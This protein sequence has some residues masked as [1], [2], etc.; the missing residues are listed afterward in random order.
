M[1]GDAGGVD[2]IGAIVGNG[3]ATGG[4]GVGA[5]GMIFDGWKIVPEGGGGPHYYLLLFLYFKRG[6]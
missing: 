6:V 3:S 5:E 4:A 1:V 2:V